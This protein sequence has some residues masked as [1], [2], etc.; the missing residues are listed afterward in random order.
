MLLGY[1]FTFLH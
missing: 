1:I